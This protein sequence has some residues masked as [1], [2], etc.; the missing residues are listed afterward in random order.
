MARRKVGL[1]WHIQWRCRAELH[2]HPT[3]VGAYD[4]AVGTAVQAA[5]PTL[6][7]FWHWH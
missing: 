3:V 6:L 1:A 2:P 4:T 7:A 5:M